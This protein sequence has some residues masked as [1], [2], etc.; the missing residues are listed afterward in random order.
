MP[1]YQ[2]LVA[3]VPGVSVPEHPSKDLC[4]AL[5]FGDSY[6]DFRSSGDL[7]NF[8]KR[9]LLPDGGNPFLT[10]PTSSTKKIDEVYRI[11]NYLSHYSQKSRRSLMAL[12]RGEYEMDRFYEPGRFLLAYDGRRLWT[13]FDAFERASNQMRAWCEQTTQ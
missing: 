8:S 5:V 9:I 10:I 6:R 12:Y 7:K 11:R 4:H 2:H 13:Y 1:P 3:Q